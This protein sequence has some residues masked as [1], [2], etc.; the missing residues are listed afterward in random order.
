MSAVDVSYIRLARIRMYTRG[1]DDVTAVTFHVDTVSDRPVFNSSAGM[2]EIQVLS[3]VAAACLHSHRFRYRA[4]LL[5]QFAQCFKTAASGIHV[6]DDQ[7]RLHTAGYAD[8]G[9]W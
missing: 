8:V 3:T 4:V 2:L 9:G 1:S 7:T 6:S 5:C